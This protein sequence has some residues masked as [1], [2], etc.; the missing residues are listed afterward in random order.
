MR[1]WR[2]IREPTLDELL[3][4]EIMGRM[5]R[6]AGIDE[7][8]LRDRLAALARRVVTPDPSPSC[9]GACV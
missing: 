1:T 6:S 3:D 4:D 2:T 9:C 7:H 5:M 8:E